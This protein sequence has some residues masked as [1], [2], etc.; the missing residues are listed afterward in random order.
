LPLHHCLGPTSKGRE[1]KGRKGRGG[2]EEEGR[3]EFVTVCPQP[4]RVIDACG[5]EEL[6][7]GLY[8]NTV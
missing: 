5:R 1:A 7:W 2:G 6:G 3:E 4:W 8:C